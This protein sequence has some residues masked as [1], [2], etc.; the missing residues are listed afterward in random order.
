MGEQK[1]CDA[2]RCVYMSPSP[3]AMLLSVHLQSSQHGHR[4]VG[5]KTLQLELPF[6]KT[7]QGNVYNTGHFLSSCFCEERV[8]FSDTSQQKSVQQSTAYVQWVTDQSVT[9]KGVFKREN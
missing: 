5:K 9:P 4:T 8:H 6:T 3:R 2:C 7:M 1:C